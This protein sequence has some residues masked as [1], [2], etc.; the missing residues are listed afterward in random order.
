MKNQCN[1]RTFKKFILYV[2]SFL[3]VAGASFLKII[4]TTA[5]LN[6]RDLL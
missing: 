1:S 3:D 5:F 4:Y 2:F 6:E